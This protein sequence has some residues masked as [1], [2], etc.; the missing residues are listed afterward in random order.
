MPLGTAVHT[1]LERKLIHN[2]DIPLEEVFFPLVREQRKIEKDTTQW[3]AGGPKAAPFM[4]QQVIDMGKECIENGLAWFKDFEIEHVEYDISGSLPELDIPVKGFADYTGVHKKHGK[5]VVDA[6]TSARKPKN[7]VQLETYCARYEMMHGDRPNGYW[8]M[9]RSGAEPKT[10]KA[11][12]VDMAELD[13]EALGRRY[14][15]V[16][17]KMQAKLYPA[18]ATF[19]DFCAQRP[20]C[21][22]QS[23]STKRANYYDKSDEDGYPF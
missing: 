6:K 8:L 16:Y 12:F 2:E 18:T 15:A 22:V 17:E 13:V 3:L 5:L 11:R 14:Q 1:V 9:L 4:G 20:N 23:G 21:L 10:D 7:N 19:C